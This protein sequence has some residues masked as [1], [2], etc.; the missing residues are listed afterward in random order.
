MHNRLP[1]GLE[2]RRLDSERA[3]LSLPMGSLPSLTPAESSI[4]LAILQGH[5]KRA[6]AHARGTSVR[7]VARHVDALYRKLGVTSRNE[8]CMRIWDLLAGP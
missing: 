3:V 4:L 8:L 1:K 5:S 7:T 6:I 2:V